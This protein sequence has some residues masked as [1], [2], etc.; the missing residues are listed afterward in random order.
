MGWERVPHLRRRDQGRKHYQYRRPPISR[1]SPHKFHE[2]RQ[3]RNVLFLEYG[4]WV[5][6]QRFVQHGSP[7]MLRFDSDPVSS[8]AG[9]ARCA[10]REHADRLCDMT[11]RRSKNPPPLHPLL[12]SACRCALSKAAICMACERWV[13]HYHAI[14]ERRI[15]HERQRDA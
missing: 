2:Q 11:E 15:A 10:P 3:Q 9:T 14:T 1:I 8:N 4:I 6:M 12:F 7:R 5:S 13:R